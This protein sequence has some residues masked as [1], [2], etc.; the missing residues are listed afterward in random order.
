MKQWNTIEGK[1]VMTAE[2][3]LHLFELGA[4]CESKNDVYDI[5]AG[6]H[7]C[8]MTA[9]AVFGGYYKVNDRW[10]ADFAVEEKTWRRLGNIR[11]DELAGCYCSSWNHAEGKRELGVSVMDEE[12]EASFHGKWMAAEDRDV[13][14]F[15]GI[16]VGWG[17][18]GEPVV[19]PTSVP[20]KVSK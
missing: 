15:S 4:K 11:Y 1:D 14:E 12:W 13:Y 9:A 20:K 8:D 19:I 10:N 2:Y 3:A 17:S 5:L 7:Q 18:D 16:Q 6:L